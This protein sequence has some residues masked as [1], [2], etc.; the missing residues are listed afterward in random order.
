MKR[1]KIVELEVAPAKN[2][3]EQSLVERG[4]EVCGIASGDEQIT[5]VPEEQYRVV[6]HSKM[7]VLMCGHSASMPPI[8]L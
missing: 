7:N 6:M 1:K 2:L 3:K 8:Q 5:E 4:R